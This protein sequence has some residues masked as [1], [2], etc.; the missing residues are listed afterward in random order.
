[1]GLA[2]L[3]IWI[4]TA[5]G[6]SYLLAKW[7]AGGGRQDSSGTRLAPALIFGHFGLAAAGL[8][9]WLIY[10]V[11]ANGPIGWVAFI[12]LVP[13]ALLGF[14]MLAK[15]IPTYRA[16]RGITGGGNHPAQAAAVEAP[17]RSFPVVVVVA[18][19]LLAVVTVVLVLLALL[20]IGGS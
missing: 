18:H 12:V 14:A 10:L 3:I 4:V 2:A 5:L 13:V 19:G 6:G 16:S 1:M 8:V 11:T 7:I 15:W 9:L 20:Q 17:E